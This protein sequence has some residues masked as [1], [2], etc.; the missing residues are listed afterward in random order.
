[1]VDLQ[2]GKRIGV[3]FYSRWAV[4]QHSTSNGWLAVDR[5]VNPRTIAKLVQLRLLQ[6]VLKDGGYEE[7]ILTEKGANY[8]NI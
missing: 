6:V 8:V 7:A 2:E 5:R 1:L 4:W 3:A